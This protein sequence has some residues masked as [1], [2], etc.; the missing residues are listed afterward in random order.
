MKYT[1]HDRGA[2]F[3]CCSIRCSRCR[4]LRQQAGGRRAPP[5][6][7]TVSQPLQKTITEWDEYTGRFVAVATVEVRARVSGFH[8]IHPFQGWSDRQAGDLLF[9]IDPRPYRLAVEQAKA[10]LERARAKLEI[11]T[12]RR[13]AGDAAGAQPDLDRTGVRY[14]K[15]DAARRRRRRSPRRRRLSSRPSSISNGPRCARPSP[16]EF[17]IGASTPAI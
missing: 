13:R 1:R 5:P 6:A 14:A 10:D 3:H 8:R 7:V 12:S 9:V 15:V 2:H 16:G 11:A 4:R 17:P